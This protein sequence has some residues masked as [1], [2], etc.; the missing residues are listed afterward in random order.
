MELVLLGESPNFY[1]SPAPL[2]ALG[3]P[4][5]PQQGGLSASGPPH[6]AHTLPR[7]ELQ[8]ELAQ[9]QGHVLP[10]AERNVLR[11]RLLRFF[12]FEAEVSGC[13]SVETSEV[14]QEELTGLPCWLG[15]VAFP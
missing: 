14:S 11:S 15:G 1:D 13:F 2:Q 3:L 4:V 9:D 6:H 7:K 5:A 10:I 8:A 12:E